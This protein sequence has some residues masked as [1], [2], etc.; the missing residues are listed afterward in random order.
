MTPEL[1]ASLYERLTTSQEIG[2]LRI[3]LAS[4]KQV[5]EFDFIHY[6]TSQPNLT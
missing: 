5:K 3:A 2:N 1:L 4:L 6:Y